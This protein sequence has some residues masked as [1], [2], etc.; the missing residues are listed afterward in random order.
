MFFFRL[1]PVFLAMFFIWKPVLAEE[2]KKIQDN[3]FL[4]EEAY[5]QEDGVI[6]HIQAFQY[7]KG[8]KWAYTFTQEWPVPKQTHQLS[9]T[10]PISRMEAPD[11]KSGLGDILIN[12]RYQAVMKGNIAASPRFSIVLPTGNYKKGLG[13]GTV[14]YQ[15]NVPVSVELSD[16]FVTHWNLGWTFTPQAKNEAGEKA[17]TLATNYGASLIYL[18]TENVNLMLEA[19]GSAG[20][21]VAGQGV[22]EPE[23]SFFINPGMR[24]AINCASGLQIVP[25]VSF[26]IGIG[27]SKGEY[28]VLTYLSFEHPFF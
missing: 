8:A 2:T 25:G 20:Q 16:K 11:R 12:Y 7:M 15:V 27:P 13:T 9:Y 17:D 19:A 14:G 23:N 6:Q 28:G 5:N 21:A 1:L 26:P 10:I 22:T 4:L 3:S 18:A 24:F